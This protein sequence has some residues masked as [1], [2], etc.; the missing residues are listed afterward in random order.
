LTP[1]SGHPAEITFLNQIRQ[2]LDRH[3]VSLH[4][5]PTGRGPG[6][7]EFWVWLEGHDGTIHTQDGRLTNDNLLEYWLRAIPGYYNALRAPISKPNSVSSSDGFW[8]GLGAQEGGTLFVAGR[9]TMV[10][11][12]YSPLEYKDS[13]VLNI[14]HWRLGLGLGASIGAALIIAIGAKTPE[15]FDGLKVGGFDFKAGLGE[16]WG[17]FAESIGDLG[18]AAKVANSAGSL[19][20][21]SN[22]SVKQWQVLAVAVRN[23]VKGAKLLNANKPTVVVMPIP[24]AGAALE[25]SVYYAWGHCSVL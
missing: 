22:L 21:K 1:D 7:A 11:I 17:A 14:S 25:A 2:D 10:G 9:D 16:N 3:G 8:F 15:G 5:G 6:P 24:L 23:G 19:F 20:A 13:F 12:M 4:V 18:L